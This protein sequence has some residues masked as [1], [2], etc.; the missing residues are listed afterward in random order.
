MMI[1]EF[2]S[3]DTANPPLINELSNFEEA[4]PPEHLQMLKALSGLPEHPI[5]WTKD[6]QTFIEDQKRFWKWVAGIIDYLQREQLGFVCINPLDNP[7]LHPTQR[8]RL[9]VNASYRFSQLNLIIV[10]W[11]LIKKE[12][13]RNHKSFSFNNPREL[14]TELCRQQA[15]IEITDSITDSITD[16]NTNESIGKVRENYRYRSSFY[17]DRL[18]AKE[19]EQALEICRKSEYWENFVVYA[20]WEKKF[21]GLSRGNLE[22]RD[23]WK[24]YLAAHKKLS[25][26]WCD[27][28]TKNTYRLILPKWTYGYAI[29]PQ[30]SQRLWK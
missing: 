26:F 24:K 17:R 2:G 28:K 7:S 10:G 4:L 14:F 12:A 19:T 3:E 21:S 13:N 30:T 15:T 25:A 23:C 8:L 6:Q 5:L 16:G 1:E 18:K 22:M 9:E 20:I 11:D 27:N 29:N